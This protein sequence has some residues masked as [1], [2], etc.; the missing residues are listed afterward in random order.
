MSHSLDESDRYTVDKI[1]IDRAVE[2]VYEVSAKYFEVRVGWWR[3]AI[4]SS[5]R[6]VG[7]V[8]TTVFAE[9]SRWKENKPQGTILYMGVLPGFLGCGYALELILEATRTCMAAGC[10]RIFCDTGSDNFPV[11]AAFRKAGYQERKP[12]R[13]PLA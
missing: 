12:W 6:K 3:A 11:V 4:D 8:L 7:F 1:G 9:S 2:E 10:W 13:R 5:G